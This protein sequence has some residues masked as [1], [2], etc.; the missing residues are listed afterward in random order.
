[1]TAQLFRFTMFTDRDGK[2]PV[3]GAG[4]AGFEPLAH[5]SFML[6]EEALTCSSAT[7]GLNRVAAHGAADET[8]R[9][10]D[11]GAFR[12]NYPEHINFWFSYRWISWG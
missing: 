1:M 8:R 4:R 3:V 2:Y 12:W 6:T 9:L 5:L 7:T 11:L 10:R